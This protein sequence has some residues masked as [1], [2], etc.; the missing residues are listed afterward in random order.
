MALEDGSAATQWQHDPNEPR[1]CTCNDVSYGE[2][3][4]CDN[5]DV[6]GLLMY[7]AFAEVYWH[8]SHC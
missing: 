5:E 1:Y 6:S 7:C 3:V 2:M 4:G 8:L